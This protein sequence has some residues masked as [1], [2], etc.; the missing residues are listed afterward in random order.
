VLY[1]F[2]MMNDLFDTRGAAPGWSE[3]LG[4]GTTFFR[5]MIVNDAPAILEQIRQISEM[6]PLRN[7]VTPGGK[8]MSVA[9]SNCGAL[10][11]V[12]D[13][14]GYRYQANDPLTQKPWPA[15][16]ALFLALAQ[17]AAEL[18]GYPG[19]QP[20]V[21]LI[22]RYGIGARMGLHQ[23]RDERDLTAPIVSFSLGLPAKFIWGGLQRTGPTRRFTVEHGDVLVWG[24][25]D[26][27]RFH[28]VAPLKPG[29]HPLTGE[30][31]FN[32]T[33]RQTGAG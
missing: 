18:A 22:N 8:K 15:M 24:G 12:S 29:H 30:L 17:R 1:T 6:A 19:F 5:G 7:L 3:P 28:G 23:D 10:G 16:P 25:P 13:H 21:C 14:A 9:M 33:F 32:I 31:R 4:S 2:A 20:N 26:R 27:L 11:W